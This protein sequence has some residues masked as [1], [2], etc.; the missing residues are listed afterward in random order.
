MSVA[1][2]IAKTRDLIRYGQKAPL[3]IL[4]LCKFN[5]GCRGNRHHESLRYVNHI[6]SYPMSLMSVAVETA[7]GRG[8]IRNRLNA[9]ACNLFLSDF[10]MGGRRDRNH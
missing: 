3:T 4:F 7:N 9:T 5:A 1:V 10:V 6:S 2:G 8:F